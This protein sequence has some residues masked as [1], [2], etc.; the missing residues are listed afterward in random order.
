MKWKIREVETDTLD[1][2][3][4]KCKEERDYVGIKK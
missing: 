3:F 2:A 4:E 1:Y